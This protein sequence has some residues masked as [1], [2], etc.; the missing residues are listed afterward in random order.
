[1]IDELEIDFP[2]IDNI[3]ENELI[4]KID[5]EWYLNDFHGLDWD[6]PEFCLEA[7]EVDQ[8]DGNE[9]VYFDSDDIRICLCN[10]QKMAN[11]LIQKNHLRR[12][13]RFL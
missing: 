1:M 5:N 6:H 7:N 3:Q 9:Y 11:V 13:L 12:N 4:K 8:N 2:E 10:K